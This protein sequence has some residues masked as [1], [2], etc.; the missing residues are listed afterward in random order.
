MPDATRNFAVSSRGRSRADGGNGKSAR[1]IPVGNG[2]ANGVVMGNGQ[3]PSN[4]SRNHSAIMLC[5][6]ASGRLW[7]DKAVR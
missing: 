6:K 4:S 5:S 2:F 3:V 7:K 1:Y